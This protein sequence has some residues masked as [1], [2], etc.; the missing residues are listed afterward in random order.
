MDYHPKFISS[1]VI[2]VS[3]K[4]ILASSFLHVIL[5]VSGRTD[6]KYLQ[7]FTEWFHR[8]FSVVEKTISRHTALEP[9]LRVQMSKKQV[10]NNRM[11][12]YVFVCI[13]RAMGIHCRLVLSFQAV[14]LRP[15]SD[16]LCS[17]S[18]KPDEKSKASTEKGQKTKEACA[19]RNVEILKAG[20][21]ESGVGTSAECDELKI[22]KVSNLKESGGRKVNLGK[23]KASGEESRSKTK[24][25]SKTVDSKTRKSLLK[26]DET[27]K[28]ESKLKLAVKCNITEEQAKVKT[29][30]ISPPKLRKDDL[31]VS[32]RSKK[33][34]G[35]RKICLEK[36][37]SARS[38]S[39]EPAK[40]YNLLCSGEKAA[41]RSRSAEK[42]NCKGKAGTLKSGGRAKKEVF[43]IKIP[44]IEIKQLDGKYIV[45]RLLLM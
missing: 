7:Q 13:L 9:V 6:L 15:P 24:R 41:T 12:V 4:K 17:L 28:R 25:E 39:A 33:S 23:L 31:K 14:P 36:P 29:E 11:L 16:E 5:V 40:E 44:K 34:G 8:T 26:N 22:E 32:A 3:I 10:S 38:K 18:T 42:Q 1:F 37:K 20:T 2:Y 19:K 30:K 43:K 45:P 21:V 35:D 27:S